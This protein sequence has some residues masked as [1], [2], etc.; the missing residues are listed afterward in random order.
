[1]AHVISNSF[2]QFLLIHVQTCSIYVCKV[3]KDVRFHFTR[4]IRE[5]ISLYIVYSQ[6][7]LLQINFPLSLLRLNTVVWP[8]ENASNLSATLL[9]VWATKY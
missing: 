8:S 3:V 4:N 1:M 5:M 2:Q 6:R 9:L 7:K